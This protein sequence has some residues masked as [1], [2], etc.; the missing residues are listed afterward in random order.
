MLVEI[1]LAAAAIDVDFQRVELGPHALDQLQGLGR[2]LFGGLLFGDLE[3]MGGAA[4]LGVFQPFANRDVA[5]GNLQCPRQHLFG[6]LEPF[7]ARVQVGQLQIQG[8]VVGLLADLPFQLFDGRELHRGFAAAVGLGGLVGHHVGAVFGPLV[9]AVAD[10]FFDRQLADSPGR[11]FVSGLGLLDAMPAGDRLVELS[12]PRQD[13]PANAIDFRVLRIDVQRL[14]QINELRLVEIQG[15]ARAGQGHQRRDIPGI[16][17][18]HL[19]AVLE[20]RFPILRVGRLLDAALERGRLGSAGETRALPVVVV[21]LDQVVQELLDVNAV[22]RIADDALRQHVGGVVEI[23]LGGAAAAVLETGLQPPAHGRGQGR[24]RSGLIVTGA[25]AHVRGGPCRAA[26][27]STI[28][29]RRV[30][31]YILAGMPRQNNACARVV[32]A[33]D[34]ACVDDNRGETQPRHRNGRDAI[35]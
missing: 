16:D 20:H 17:L 33:L 14:F 35:P 26:S 34:D 6:R 28:I 5:A 4:A 25:G 11:L 21:F 29:G 30:E 3:L 15:I 31:T 19:D 32:A 13:A 12:H 27:W 24:S 9:T 8:Q 1:A 10:R 23:A 18:E 2:L 22:A 7:L